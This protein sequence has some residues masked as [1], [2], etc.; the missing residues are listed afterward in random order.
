MR[1]KDVGNCPCNPGIN[2]ED[3]RPPCYRCGW[4]PEV[5]KQRLKEIKGEVNSHEK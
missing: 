4:N 3:L 5:S 1:R 2:C